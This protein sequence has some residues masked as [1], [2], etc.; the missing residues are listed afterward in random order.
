MTMK[1]QAPNVYLH[2]SKNEASLLGGGMVMTIEASLSLKDDADDSPRGLAAYSLD[3]SDKRGGMRFFKVTTRVYA[4]HPD[5]NVEANLE[6]CGLDGE[7]VNRLDKAYEGRAWITRQFAK[8]ASAAGPATDAASVYVR[9]ANICKCKGI[10]KH[11]TGNWRSG[12]WSVMGMD[13]I[14]FSVNDAIR[15]FREKHAP[16]ASDAAVA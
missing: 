11:S 6:C 13:M 10:I 3:E 4:D 16:K 8:L 7:D 9:F 15:T 14:A 5:W 1:N 2:I 12:Q